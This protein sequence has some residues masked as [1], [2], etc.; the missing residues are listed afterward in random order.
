MKM[1]GK[2]DK[3]DLWYKYGCLQFINVWK[4]FLWFSHLD[5]GCLWTEWCCKD[6]KYV[7]ENVEV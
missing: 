6:Y 2:K 1:L 3:E 5:N 7:T 4:L